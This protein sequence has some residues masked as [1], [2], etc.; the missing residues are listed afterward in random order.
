MDELLLL[1]LT[2]VCISFSYMGK[3][4]IKVIYAWSDVGVAPHVFIG[5][6]TEVDTSL[7]RHLPKEPLH[8]A[9]KTLH[10]VRAAP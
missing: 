7:H 6:F 2:D 9:P 3:E 1:M 4:H 5:V 8:G 10:F